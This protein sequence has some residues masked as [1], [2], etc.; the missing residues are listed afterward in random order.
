VSPTSGPWPALTTSQNLW[1]RIGVAP[2]F[3]AK[4][5][6]A[7]LAA[8]DRPS[9]ADVAA[10]VRTHEDHVRLKRRNPSST[11]FFTSRLACALG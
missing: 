5:G 2:C 8:I 3:L 1:D 6:K 7:T 4:P 11:R 10:C 9:D